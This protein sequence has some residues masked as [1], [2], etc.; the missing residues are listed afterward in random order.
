MMGGEPAGENK[1]PNPYIHKTG[2]KCLC[3]GKSARKQWEIHGKDGDG[4]EEHDGSAVVGDVGFAMGD[5]EGGTVVVPLGFERWVFATEAYGVK[6]GRTDEEDEGGE[7][8]KL[9]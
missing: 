3:F 7:E 2:S 4:S 8:S 9:R 5:E 1:C 6:H